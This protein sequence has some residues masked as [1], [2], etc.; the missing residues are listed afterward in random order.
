[1]A[2]TQAIYYRDQHGVEPVAQFM[3]KL[4]AK[5]IAKIDAFVEE[6]LNGQPP[7]AP[8]PEHPVTSQIDGE[9]RERTRS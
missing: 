1:V 8:P 3:E 7:N 5:R 9:L 2:E 6:H 4:P